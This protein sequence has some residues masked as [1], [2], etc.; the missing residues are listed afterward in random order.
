[1]PSHQ[2]P[3]GNIGQSSPCI[4]DH[5]LRPSR[6]HA[7]TCRRLQIYTPF[8]ERRQKPV[9]FSSATQNSSWTVSSNREHRPATAPQSRP[10]PRV[11]LASSKGVWIR[12]YPFKLYRTRHKSVF[13]LYQTRHTR[14]AARKVDGTCELTMSSPV[15]RRSLMIDGARPTR[16]DLSLKDCSFT[17]SSSVA[18]RIYHRNISPSLRLSA[19]FKMRVNHPWP[20][21]DLHKIHVN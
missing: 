18:I 5:L 20:L 4:T 17:Q 9:S 13:K 10:A 16:H 7:P 1:M 19:A 14:A 8:S 2:R 21:V 3:V 15:G 6:Q 11:L 12:A